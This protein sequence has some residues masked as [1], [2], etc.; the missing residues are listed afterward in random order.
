MLETVLVDIG[1]A[2]VSDVL[3]EAVDELTGRT[4]RKW[5]VILLALLVGGITTAV[6]IRKRRRAAAAAASATAAP[7]GAPA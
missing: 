4:A 1:D 3:Q 2:V 5:A 6:I 7:E